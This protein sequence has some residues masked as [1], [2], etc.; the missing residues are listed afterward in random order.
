MNFDAKTGQYYLPTSLTKKKIKKTTPK[1]PKPN[2]KQLLRKGLYTTVSGLAV[3]SKP[4]VKY[5]FWLSANA[6]TD[7]LA[8]VKLNLAK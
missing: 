4:T 3:T 8:H 2:L 5:M 6:A 1:K 7:P